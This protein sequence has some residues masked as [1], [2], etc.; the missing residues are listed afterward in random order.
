MAK[1][2]L[3]RGVISGKSRPIAGSHVRSHP[4]RPYLDHELGR[5][6]ASSHE[7]AFRF[8]FVIA[9]SVLAT[10]LILHWKG[11]AY[12]SSAIRRRFLRQERYAGRYLQ[13]LWR[14]GEVRYSFLNIFY[15][16]RRRRY[17]IA[18]RT[19]NP[20]GEQ[21]ADFA[22][23]HVFVPAGKD[24]A[25]EFI[26]RASDFLRGFTRMTLE[27]C[28]EDYIQG[29]GVVITFD[30]WPRAYPVRFKHLLARHVLVAL[31]V[32]SPIDS[33]EEPDFVRKFHAAFGASVME[34]FG[35]AA[36]TKAQPV[37]ESSLT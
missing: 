34:G 26:W 17:E 10:L 15:N 19:Y 32:R 22:A 6:S 18:G 8:L 12:R 21:L 30:A 28:D 7:E 4:G 35:G 9:L 23:A 31:G 2:V 13:A 3:K 29:G 36:K 1:N 16:P 27:D 24:P 11:I 20:A 5:G 33:S 37:T 25:I 14:D